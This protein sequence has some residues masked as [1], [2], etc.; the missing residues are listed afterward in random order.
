MLPGVRI[1]DIE[2]TLKV[3]ECKHFTRAGAKLHKDQ[4]TVSRCIKRVEQGIGAELIDRHAHPVR[5]TKAGSLF[6]YWGRKGLHALE[7]GFSE[8]RRAGETNHSVL[9]VGYTSYLDLDILA[10]MQHRASAPDAGFAHNEHSSSTSEIISSVLSGRWDCGFIISPAAMDGLV[11]VPL[12]QEPFGLMMASDHQLARKRRIGICDLRDVPLILPALERNTGFRSW[13][14]E[15]CT[16]EGVKPKVAHEVSNPHEAG[17]LASQRVGLALM[18]KSA[19]NNLRKGGTVFR[20][21]SADDLYA[22]IQLV[23]RDEPQTPRLASFVKATLRM[24]ERLLRGK[25]EF[26]PR[27]QSLIPRPTVK[28]WWDGHAG[29][30]NGHAASA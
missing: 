30:R 28:E 8:I 10:Y 14:V 12:Y 13:F 24:R 25:M 21:F 22:E 5:P 15:R 6:L 29:H 16:A 2:T 23:F 26:G 19:S 4:T 3:I 1:E 20:P 17:F 27:Q 11:G 7:R 9:H 18:P